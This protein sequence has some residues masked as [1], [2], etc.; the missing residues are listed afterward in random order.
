ME[1]LLLFAAVYLLHLVPVFAPPTWM[2]IALIALNRPELNPMGVAVIAATAATL[3]RVTL[4]CGARFL[5]RE[6]WMG[7]ATRANVD[8]L[9]RMISRR[10]GA[11]YGLLLFYLYS[12][13]SNFLF[14]AHA[15]MRLPLLM[16]AL[17]FLCGR[18]ATYTLW[19][20]ATHTVAQQFRLE[21]RDWGSYLGGY[22][23]IT[24]CILLILMWLFM[25]LDWRSLIEQRRVQLLDR[26]EQ[27][28]HEDEGGQPP[29]SS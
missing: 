3:G 23:L 18:L 22:F 21:G 28:E 20:M 4:A 14:I 11:R 2:A 16:I 19:G 12:P 10:S 25:R 26:L 5:V 27:R 29:R 1:A 13:A 8:M 24:Q 15:L 9:G 17:P 6:R 7:A